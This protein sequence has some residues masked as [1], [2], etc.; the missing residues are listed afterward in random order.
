MRLEVIWNLLLGGAGTA[1]VWI[2]SLRLETTSERIA[3]YHR[4]PE[5][6]KGAVI[7][8]GF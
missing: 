4:I 3:D 7:G 8:G 6:V 5:I 2:S 1:I